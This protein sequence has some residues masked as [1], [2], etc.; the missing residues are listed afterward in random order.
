MKVNRKRDIDTCGIYIIRNI[1]NNKVYIGK[2]I[3]IYKR[4]IQHVH[5]LRTKSKDENI[6]LI[7]SW[8]K[9]GENSF[10]YIIVEYLEKN[11]ELL[12]ERELYW[13]KIYNSTNRNFGYNMRLD[14]STR[15][16]LPQETKD[17]MS[18]SKIEMYNNP[19]YDTSKHSHTFW[20]DNPEAK[21]EMAKKVSKNRRKYTFKQ[22]SINGELIR[23]WESVNSIIEENPNYKW[24]NI[25]SVCNGYKKSYMGFKWEKLKRV[26]NT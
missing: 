4:I 2:S 8:H 3:N 13:M 14:T 18:K 7:H 9:Y 25:Y 22:Y 21:L 10:E 20:K 1:K 16:I 5:T 24:Q 17:R 12:A 23:E 11:E 26:D 15:C 6:H 19:D